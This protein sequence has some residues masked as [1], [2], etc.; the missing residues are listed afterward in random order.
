MSFMNRIIAIIGPTAAGKTEIGIALAQQ[1]N[2][3]ILSADSMAVYRGMDIGTAKPDSKQQSAVRFHLIDIA[4]PDERFSAAEYN[5]HA[6]TA[7]KDISLRGKQPILVGGTGF[8][9]RAFLENFSLTG[10]PCNQELRRQLEEEGSINGLPFLH[11]RLQKLDPEAAKRIHPNDK[12]R[13]VRALEVCIGTGEPI[14]AQQNRDRQNRVK[15]SSIKFALHLSREELY[16][17]I[18]A[19]VEHMLAAGLEQEVR[20]LLERGFS[21]DCT[22]MR[23]LGYKEMCSFIRG[24]M[25]F[26]A[27][28]D[29]I[30][31][32]TRKFS[33][34]Q[35][36][37]FRAETD[38]IWLNIDGEPK[39]Q[40]V[41]RIIDRL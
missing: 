17:R 14:S 13:I 10:A 1:L 9:I 24:E 19:R 32:N 18:D 2:G 39:N 16:Q 3:E 41:Q 26:R 30:K 6:D 20:G 29:A 22:S 8:Y 31:Q 28:V 27:S 23:S 40:T 4:E 5:L 37:W 36:T 33:K 15:R 38:L 25:D 12:M 34:R 11:S 7:L 35:L 21:S